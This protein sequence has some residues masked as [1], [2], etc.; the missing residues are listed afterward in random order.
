LASTDWGSTD[1]GST[2]WGSTDWG[3][4]DW[5]STDWGSIDWSSN[6]LKSIWRVKVTLDRRVYFVGMR[7]TDYGPVGR[8]K[9]IY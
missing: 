4:T 8:V 5:G 6:S 3:S 1:W 9:A 7:M 2:D